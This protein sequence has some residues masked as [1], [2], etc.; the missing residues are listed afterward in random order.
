MPVRGDQ[1]GGDGGE[2][3]E[4]DEAGLL[5][6]GGP[7]EADDAEADAV[8][9]AIDAKMDERRKQRRE[10]RE[11][12]EMLKYLELRPKIQQQFA[13]LK[14]DLASVSEDEWAAIPDIGDRGKRQKRP[15]RYGNGNYFLW[16]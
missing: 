13:D 10:A 11:K 1:D 15:E 3:D 12:E 5:G 6:R 14:R 7:Y 8:Y 2:N 4:D 9:G 16:Y